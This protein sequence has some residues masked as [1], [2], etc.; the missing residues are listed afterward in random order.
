MAIGAISSRGGLAV[1][2]IVGLYHCVVV[3]GCVCVESKGSRSEKTRCVDACRESGT[4]QTCGK[5]P[6][7][8]NTGRRDAVWVRR[9]AT[10]G[11]CCET[12]ELESLREGNDPYKGHTLRPLMLRLIAEF[13]HGGG[14][15][16][17][18]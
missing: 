13:C 9:G 5:L 12:G 10:D 3:C 4:R 16:D 15:S 1:C 8:H 17:T 18:D 7:F 14:L 11:A 6:V 2:A